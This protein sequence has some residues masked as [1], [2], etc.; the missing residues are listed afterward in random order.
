MKKIAFCLQTMVLGGVE[1]ELIAVLN[2][3]QHDFDIT[4]ILLYQEDTAILNKIPKSVKIKIIGIEEGYYWNSTTVLI[5]KRIKKGKFI[6]AASIGLK[7]LIGVGM[8]ASNTNISD[9]PSV[10][11][12]FD[13]AICY[14]IHSPLL[15]KYVTEKVCADKKIAWVH[16]DF[17]ASGYSIQKLKEYV[18]EYDEYV[19]V[20]KKVEQ[21]FRDLCPWYQGGI[22]TAYNYLETEEILT[23]S[24]EKID[25]PEFIDEKGI[26][27]LTVG[28]FTEQK[29]MDI[30]IEACSLLKKQGVSFHW[31]LIGYGELEEKL[32][33]LIKEYDIEDCFTILGKKTNPYPY[34]KNCDIFVLPSRHEAYPLTIMEA[35][36]LN[37]PIVCTNFDGADEQIDNGCNG[38]IAPLNDPMALC[39][40]ISELI[41]SK[42]TRDAFTK[43]LEIWEPEDALKKIVKHFE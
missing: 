42:E 25:E 24:N 2:K 16:N 8:T 15:L 21:E 19:A 17:Y 41:A 36:I 30:A 12:K 20:S 26:K 31:F 38:I 29:G 28:R 43:E 13:S 9:I 5:K 37:R 10:D 14:H 40:K 7:R 11:E 6:E 35:K 39:E 18:V 32:R 4:L 34:I 23:L 33:S 22:S 3:I 1:K 27:L